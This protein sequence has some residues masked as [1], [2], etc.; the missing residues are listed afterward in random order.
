MLFA[1]KKG[2]FFAHKQE[3]TGRDLKKTNKQLLFY[4]R[5]IINLT[6]LKES[7]GFKDRQIWTSITS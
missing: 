7:S 4:R 6:L 3:K 1:Q 5:V 2:I